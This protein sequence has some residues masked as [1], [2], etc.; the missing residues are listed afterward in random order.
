MS[1]GVEMAQDW[2]GQMAP[3]TLSDQD[4]IEAFQQNIEMVRNRAAG[5][6]KKMK[7]WPRARLVAL[8]I[9][10]GG[11]GS[12]SRDS[13]VAISHPTGEVRPQVPDKRTGSDLTS[14]LALS[15]FLSA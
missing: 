4:E 8:P 11:V 2:L 3:G 15:A 9:S 5:S 10:N 13:D 14:R 7:S 6:T 1:I 12:A